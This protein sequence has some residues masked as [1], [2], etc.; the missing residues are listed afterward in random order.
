MN[1]T[2]K[3]NSA[4]VRKSLSVSASLSR[5]PR[6]RKYKIGP[7]RTPGPASLC[8]NVTF[9]LSETQGCE[10]DPFSSSRSLTHQPCTENW[11]QLTDKITWRSHKAQVSVALKFEQRLFISDPKALHFSMEDAYA[12]SVT[13]V[14]QWSP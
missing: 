14:F 13:E 6:G 3:N 1:L 9:E 7:L 4:Q 2:S 10:T 5:F 12:R 11:A 8:L